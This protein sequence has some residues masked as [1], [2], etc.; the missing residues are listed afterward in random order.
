MDAA[1]FVEFM[2]ISPSEWAL[3]LE[4]REWDPVHSQ[5]TA[6]LLR[7]ARRLPQ[8]FAIGVDQIG[9]DQRRTGQAAAAVDGMASG[10]ATA[11]EGAAS[12]AAGKLMDAVKK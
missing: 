4:D 1:S 10:A 12:E 11:I 5:L 8:L 2:G 7:A 3:A 6:K 9:Q